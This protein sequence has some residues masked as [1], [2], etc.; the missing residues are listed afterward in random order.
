MNRNK[1]GVE[2]IRVLGFV[3]ALTLLLSTIRVFAN[4]AIES[5]RK[6]FLSGSSFYNQ[7]IEL[8]HSQSGL[9]LVARYQGA[10]FYFDHELDK[11]CL[12]EVS[13]AKPLN[14][15]L[16]AS[17]RWP[18]LNSAGEIVGFVESN[19]RK[20]YFWSADL[21]AVEPNKKLPYLIIEDLS[22]IEPDSRCSG[23]DCSKGRYQGE[24]RVSAMS[25]PSSY[26]TGRIS[27]RQ[28]LGIDSQIDE[29]N[30]I[31]FP[32]VSGKSY[33][34]PAR[35]ISKYSYDLKNKSILSIPSCT[36]KDH[37]VAS[38]KPSSFRKMLFRPFAR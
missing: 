13:P 6:I 29:K 7:M 17:H 24:L 9:G 28:A 34:V 23:K 5:N 33:L 4:C 15:N 10:N 27:Y 16:D 35:D 21:K 30:K 14:C 25:P 22:K 1:T 36:G 37:V 8:D 31:L 32:A 19:Q 38:E 26:E 11:W 2:K 20:L 12:K 18:L 3:V